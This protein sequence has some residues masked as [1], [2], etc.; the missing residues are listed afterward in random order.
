VETAEIL[1]LTGAG[2]AALGLFALGWLIGMWVSDARAASAYEDGYEQARADLEQAEQDRQARLL[3][4]P[5]SARVAPRPV[6]TT[7]RDPTV[8][9]VRPYVAGNQQHV[10]RHWTR[11]EP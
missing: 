10:R 6:S 1:L 3:E 5:S 9:F 7:D 2:A 11:Y 8:Q 4:M